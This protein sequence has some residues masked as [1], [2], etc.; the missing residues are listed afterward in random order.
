LLS[1]YLTDPSGLKSSGRLIAAYLVVVGVLAFP[2]GLILPG[3]A[4]YVAAFTN[5]CFG[6]AVIF[7]G[8]TKGYDTFNWV[9][10]KLGKWLGKAEGTPAEAPATTTTEPDG[11]TQ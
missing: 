11:G 10:G 1:Q 4:S 9:R 3:M 5:Q 7:Y 8:A 2:A 6:Y